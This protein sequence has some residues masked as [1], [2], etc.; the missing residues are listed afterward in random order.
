MKQ[1]SL[2]FLL[3]AFLQT[4]VF[5]QTPQPSPAP[6]KD[7]E[8]VV[9][10]TNL[11][12]VDVTVTDKN[13]K[14]VTDL[15]ADDFEIFE[16]ESKQP[17]T[18]FSF[19]SLSQPSAAPI[20]VKQ[21][22]TGAPPA[23]PVKL[24]SAQVRRTISL[25]VDDLGMSF[26]SVAFA[27]QALKKFVDEQMQPADLVAIVR[28]SSGIGALQQFTSDK[29]QLYAA[30]ERIKWNP[31]ARGGNPLFAARQTGAIEPV[32]NGDNLSRTSKPSTLLEENAQQTEETDELKEYRE[33]LF[34]V[35]TLGAINY[36][37]KGMRELPG[38]KAI[39]LISDGFKIFTE[40]QPNQRI[41][42]ALHAL[43]DLSNRAGVVIYTMDARGLSVY[44]QNAVTDAGGLNRDPYSAGGQNLR[45][46]S[47]F[48]TQQG[49]QYLAK[50]TGGISLTNTN[51]ISKGIETML[52]D[53]KGYCLIGYEPDEAV[54]DPA[55][56]RFNEL[57]VK[58]KR[59]DLN[60]RYRS[61]FFGI[62]DTD[63]RSVPK[64]PQEKML[65]ALTSPFATGEIDLTLT[66]LFANDLKRGLLVRSFVYIKGGDLTFVEEK[67]GWYTTTFDI[68]AVTFGDNGVVVDS[69]DK[70]ETLRARAEAL[71]EIKEKG[72]VYFVTVPVKKPGAYQM[73]VVL[74]DASTSHIG[75]ASQFVEVPNLKKDR[76]TLS[77]I[78]LQRIEAKNA[79]VKTAEQVKPDADRDSAL[80]QFQIGTNVL[81]AFAVYNAKL[82]KATNQPRLTTQF[83]IF[84]EGKEI[85][86]GAEKPLEI[87]DQTDL[88]R[89]TT[90]GKIR[91]GGVLQPGE[92]VLQVV[93]RDTLAKVN[94][95]TATQWVDF[96]VVN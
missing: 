10:N 47:F 3:I 65:A 74:R 54:F 94:R 14:I 49:L 83:K 62:T 58:L 21:S 41:L 95:A 43:T 66:S 42:D 25:L 61:G 44:E 76:L 89:I 60:I 72:F 40:G 80:R 88:S 37:V 67:D 78:V 34:S 31:S 96:E 50:E 26:V 59:P 71:Q 70:S 33:D 8:V 16:N 82:D 63:A 85:F 20:A 29:R 91:V 2:T 28:T 30:I 57:R 93:I 11:I 92:Y 4:L 87:K 22:P 55:K 73:R 90:G 53:Q 38:R 52:N 12:Q 39:F 13:G 5:S 45:K 79:I 9:I 46:N 75:S 36:V 17:I 32:P 7:A 23:P 68:V 15:T 64:T 27:R 86:A 69:V 81:F 35:G 24:R 18:A 84:R 1:F 56:R 48:E 19:V 6:P 51:Q 77:G